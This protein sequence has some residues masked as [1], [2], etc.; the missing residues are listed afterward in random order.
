MY[1]CV[2]ADVSGKG[3]SAALLA[4]LLQGAF[5]FAS[6]GA[7][8]IDDVMSR[9]N[10]FLIERARGEKYA[11]VVYCTIDRSGEL[12]WANAGHPKPIVVRAN[13]ELQLLD[14]TGMPIGML[15]VAEYEVKTMQLQPGDKLVLFSDGLSEAANSDGEFFD[16]RALKEFLCAHAGI[17]CAELHAKLVEAVEDFSEAS[18]QED[19]ITML[20][21]EYQP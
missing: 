8:R 15:D 10:R 6:E 12:R 5:V 17:G 14:S 4:A 13:G 9:V 16:K 1:A 18:E 7:L 21:L 3:V 20:V 19:D 11:T 2:I